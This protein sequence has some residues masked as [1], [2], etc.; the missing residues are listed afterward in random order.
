M[1]IYIGADHNGFK[2]K[3]Q[4]ID[5]LA[6]AGYDVVDKGNLQ[7]DQ[8]DDYPDFAQAVSKAVQIDSVN[9]PTD[10]ARGILLCGSGHG[11][12]IAANR[13]QGIRACLGYNVD[14]TRIARNDD[15]CN[16]LV[17]PA[18]TV[19]ASQVNVTIETFL[20]TPFGDAERYARRVTKIDHPTI[21]L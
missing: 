19:E 2:L 20:N 17:L 5:Y 15:D 3:A 21:D 13:F 14:T 7:Y 6:N 11:I 8:S 16:V 1:K 10:P 9:N 4:I 12:Q 18:N